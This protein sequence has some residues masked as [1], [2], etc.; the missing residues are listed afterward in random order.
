V[1]PG[2]GGRN[3][4]EGRQG[5]R[6][7]VVKW[8]HAG[9]VWAGAVGGA[10]GV[11]LWIGC[12]LKIPTDSGKKA[13][14]EEEQPEQTQTT[15]DD[16]SD[17]PDVAGVWDLKLKRDDDSELTDTTMTLVQNDGDLDGNWGWGD[18][19]GDIEKDRDIDLTLKVSGGGGNKFRLKGKVKSGLNK[20]TGTW[21]STYPVPDD[22]GTWEA[23][24]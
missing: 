1:P 10:L 13:Q 11:L 18:L 8:R 9:G 15:Q 20:M 16:G 17:Y 19:D 7:R 21:T 22:D 6:A 23:H 12:D 14:E 3:A 24:R 5:R 4:A 2:P